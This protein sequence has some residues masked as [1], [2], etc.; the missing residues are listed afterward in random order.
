V[1]IGG[2]NSCFLDRIAANVRL[3]AYHVVDNNRHGLDLLRS[4]PTLPAEVV[5]HEQNVLN[6]SLPVQA[7]V[8]FSIGL[9]EHFGEADTET[10]V[11]AHLKLLKPG[12]VAIISWPTPTWLY[13]AAR[14]LCEVL[15]I[16]KF[17]D[18]RPLRPAEVKRALG[19]R[20]EIIYEKT[21]WPLILT[22]HLL[23]ARKIPQHAPPS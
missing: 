7:D 13:R 16:W 9:I 3:A 11:A 4:R 2:A 15:G 22:Q 6:L 17:P 12:G 20:G 23:V 5:L 8:V 19:G 10:A 1:E 21:L 18:E 14:G